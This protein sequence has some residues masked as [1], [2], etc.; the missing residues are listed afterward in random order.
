MGDHEKDRI[1]QKRR[2]SRSDEDEWLA[3]R[4]TVSD[5]AGKRRNG[6]HQQRRQRGCQISGDGR[7]VHHSSHIARHV[8]DDGVHRYGL[9]HHHQHRQ[10]DRLAVLARQFGEGRAGT[11]AGRGGDRV[12]AESTPNVEA[13]WQDQQTDQKRNAPAPRSKSG[14]WQRV[15]E[16]HTQGCAEQCGRA[17]AGDLPTDQ[18]AAT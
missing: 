12:L 16:Q 2:A 14:Q 11:T 5:E 6:Y 3:A 1:H 17:L 13:D 8:V 10:Q 7:H 9:P 4:P 18:I 15:A